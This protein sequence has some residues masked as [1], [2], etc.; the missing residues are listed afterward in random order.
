MKT[1]YL[2][3]YDISEDF[4]LNKILRYMKGK[5]IHLQYSVFYC[6]LN[7]KELLKIID[8][9]MAMID[10]KQ[11]DVRIYPLVTNFKAIVLGRG[12]KTPEGADIFLE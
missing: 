11:D 2:I 4:R 5:G 9:V 8:E 6:L 1:Y 7:H 10:L 12:D 3:C